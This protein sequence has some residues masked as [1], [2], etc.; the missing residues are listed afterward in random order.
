MRAYLRQWIAGAWIPRPALEA[1]RR[2][3][4]TLT[5][6]AALDAG[7]ERALAEGIDPL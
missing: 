3:V 6:R 5:S 2:D 7:L 4:D 1:L